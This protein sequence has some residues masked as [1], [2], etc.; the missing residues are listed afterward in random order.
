MTAFLASTWMRMMS[1]NHGCSCRAV[2]MDRSTYYHSLTS[3]KM[4]RMS[5]RIKLRLRRV[6]VASSSIRLTKFSLK[7]KETTICIFGTRSQPG[8]LVMDKKRSFT[9]R[10]KHTSLF[11]KK[12][13]Q[14]TSSTPRYPILRARDWSRI[15]GAMVTSFSVNMTWKRRNCNSARCS[16][17][18]L[19]ILATLALIAPLQLMSKKPSSLSAQQATVRCSRC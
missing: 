11:L 4:L 1:I 15:I 5:R 13:T 10:M 6:S 8:L 19:K 2:C 3:S 9:L 14:C 7:F 18:K 17:E 12:T 16:L